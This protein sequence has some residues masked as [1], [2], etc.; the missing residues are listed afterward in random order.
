M[1]KTGHKTKRGGTPRFA[2]CVECQKLKNCGGK[3]L[4]D[5]HY[6]MKA[7]CKLCPPPTQPTQ[8]KI[9]SLFTSPEPGSMMQEFVGEC[10]EWYVNPEDL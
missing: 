2:E 10:G 1:C 8:P 3:S 7:K 4:C 5:D 9:S 6:R